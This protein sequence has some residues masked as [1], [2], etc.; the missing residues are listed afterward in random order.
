MEQFKGDLLT[1]ECI[2]DGFSTRGRGLIAHW[3]YLAEYNPNS[4]LAN[5]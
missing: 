3:D 1:Q 5:G 4:K 2:Q